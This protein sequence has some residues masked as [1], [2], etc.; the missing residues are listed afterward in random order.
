MVIIN[1]K[2][3]EIRVAVVVPC[4]PCRG[5]SEYIGYGE[6]CKRMWYEKYCLVF[7]AE[8]RKKDNRVLVLDWK[9]RAHVGD[10]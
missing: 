3:K 6:K 2:N 8:R 10:P 1:K 4:R 5:C 9:H 7:M